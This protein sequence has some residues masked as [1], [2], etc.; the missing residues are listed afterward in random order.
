MQ[1]GNCRGN[2]SVNATVGQNFEVTK[3]Y[4]TVTP[5]PHM[6]FQGVVFDVSE[7]K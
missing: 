6:Q 7:T 5:F 3:Y 1:R 4:T 2:P